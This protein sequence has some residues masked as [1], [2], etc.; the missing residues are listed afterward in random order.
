MGR[1]RKTLKFDSMKKNLKTRIEAIEKDLAELKKEIQ[2]E[3]EVGSWWKNNTS[4]DKVRV[5]C[6]DRDMIHTINDVANRVSYSPTLFRKLFTPCEAPK[7]ETWYL[8]T[9]DLERC[10]KRGKEYKTVGE[11]P[12]KLIDEEGDVFIVKQWAKHFVSPQE[13]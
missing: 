11:D 3:I 7:K 5:M 12:L 8:C 6:N 2:P 9:K 1:F 13:R 4:V 10:F